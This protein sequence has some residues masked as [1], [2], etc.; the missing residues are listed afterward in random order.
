MK[1]K[2][3]YV[4]GASQGF[5]LALVRQLLEAGYSVAATSRK[6]E[7][8]TG[9]VGESGERF[10][11]LEVDLTKPDEIERSIARTVE[12]FGGID[13]VVNNAGYGMEGTLEEVDERQIRAIFEI[14]VFATIE[15]TK[16]A[17][18][19]L[20]AQRSGHIINFASVAGFVGAPGWSIYSATKSAVI[21]FSEV[22]ALDVKD[23]GIKVTVVA[24]SGFR[25][26]FL[27]SGS[28]VS[29]ESKIED[30]RAVAQTHER[31]A[32]MNGKQ[33]GDPEK[34]AALFI[35]LGE[36][37]DPPLHLWLGSNAVERAGAKIEA[38]ARELEQWRELSASADF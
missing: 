26:G 27:T 11:P 29:T 34:A 12:V 30:Y 33:E 23:L 17:L 5:G 18:P 1:K 20:R 31:Y 24:P 25:T 15:A 10:L 9:A 35:G 4:T 28:L 8:L 36:N 19:Y 38:M 37:P 6:L 7:G 16:Y 32:A 22:L 13:V 2:I 3:W 21:A 14:N